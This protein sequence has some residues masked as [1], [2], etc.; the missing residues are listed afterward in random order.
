VSLISSITAGGLCGR[1]VFAAGVAS[2]VVQPAC[3][4]GSC[5]AGGCVF[6]AAESGAQQHKFADIIIAKYFRDTDAQLLYTKC[7]GETALL[8]TD[9]GYGS[10]L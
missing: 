1:T 2:V 8:M 10:C 4:A 9:H 5:A 6:T 7:D 3:A